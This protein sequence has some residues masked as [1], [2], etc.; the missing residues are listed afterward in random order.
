MTSSNGRGPKKAILYARV[1]TQEQVEKGYSLAQQMEALR[2][3]AAREGYEIVEEVVDP[4]QSGASLER[5]GM[6]RLRGLVA[7]KGVY[8]VLAQ[9]RDRF[10]REPAYAYLLKREFEEHGCK[11]RALNDRGD[12]SPEGELMDGVFDQFA[13]FERA[14]TAERTRR[15]K[16]RKAQEGKILAGRRVSYGFKLN[17]GRDAYVVDEGR[18]WVLQRIFRM[19]GVEK[20]TIHKIKRTLEREGVRTPTGGQHWSSAAIRRFIYDDVYRPHTF[21]EIESLVTPEVAAR[22]DST[23]CYG[24]WWFN[25]QR[26]STKQVSEVS[27][28]GRRYRSKR[29]FSTRPKEEWIAVPVPDS[30]IPREVVDMAREALASNRRISNNGSRY[31]E[32]SGGILHCGVC[33][34]RMRTSVS[35]K[36][37]S[38]NRYFYYHCNKRHHTAEACPNRKNYRAGELEARVWGFVSDLL[39]EPERLRTGIEKMIEH[40]RE[41]MHGNPDQEAKAWADKLSEVERRRARFQD[42]AADGLIDFEELRAKLAALEETR[43]TAR[44]ELEIL[45]GRREELAELEHDCEAL[46]ER[47]TGTVSED[48]DLLSSEERHH[49]YKLLKLRV[50][51]G[52][53][54]TLE[55]S[56][57][58]VEVPKVC[59]TE[60]TPTG[61]AGITWWQP[62]PGS[63]RISRRKSG[64]KAA[65]SPA[66]ME[67]P[68][69]LISSAQG[70]IFPRPSA[71]TTT[72]TSGDPG[73]VPAR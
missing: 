25:R 34:W 48:I 37:G 29:A 53:D 9:D 6:D 19:A 8:V 46:M 26:V 49:V 44:K 18:M 11:M 28:N 66:T 67:R 52:T 65:S 3:Y 39:K 35:H 62:L 21:E 60:H 56:G 57:V 42:M 69:P 30:G 4:G 5:P 54:G 15:G 14:K 24:I 70:T 64:P 51:L 13:K 36:R 72:T 22:L 7:A 45:E 68:G 71:G 73:A 1:S 63:T 41:A 50:D 2:V 59:K 27:K 61:S 31:W 58:W 33:G 55:V 16:L 20:A 43:E 38:S 40:K 23:K 12:D 32:L 17:E 10:S 47:Y